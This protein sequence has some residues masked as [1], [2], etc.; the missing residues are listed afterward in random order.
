MKPS[1]MKTKRSRSIE[2]AVVTIG[3]VCFLLMTLMVVPF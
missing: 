3:Q 2:P 1:T